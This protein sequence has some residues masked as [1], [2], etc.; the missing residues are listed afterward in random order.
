MLTA[1]KGLRDLED[2][3]APLATLDLQ[4]HQDSRETLD[5]Q[6]SEE[7]MVPEVTPVSRVSLATQ[8]GN[9]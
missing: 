1:R 2:D 6:G 9:I 4:V 7:L 3:Q 5:P 8:V